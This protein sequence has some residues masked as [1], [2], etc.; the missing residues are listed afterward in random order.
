MDAR[1]SPPC[2]RHGRPWEVRP[3]T[4][5]VFGLLLMTATLIQ[6]CSDNDGTS[7]PKFAGG[8]AATTGFANT[9]ADIVVQLGINPNSI[10][11]GQ[12]A[13]VTAF[14]TNRNGQSLGGKRV[15]FSTSLGSLDQTVVTTNAAGQ[16][17]TTLR[18]S[19]SDVANAGGATG[20]ATVTAFVDGAIGTGVV[21]FGGN[22]VPTALAL[23]P[24]SIPL[25]EGVGP[26]GDCTTGP[27]AAG[28]FSAQFTVSGGV[29]PYSFSAA[30]AVPGATISSGGRYTAPGLGR[31]PRGFTTTDTVTVVDSTG[32]ARTGTVVITCTSTTPSP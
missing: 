14:V 26:A 15:Q 21:S 32:T 23:N 11:P 9:A 6:G 8:P 13:G 25:T 2:G 1:S 17:S 20:S 18:V 28:S 24:P 27:F 5:V 22:P 29:P 19:A 7:G 31:R 4:L 3:W 12:R 16:A 10:T 30:G